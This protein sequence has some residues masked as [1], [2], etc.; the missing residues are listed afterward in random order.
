MDMN[1][2]ALRN[3]I[4]GIGENNGSLREDGFIITVASEIMAIVCLAED[5]MDLRSRLSKIVLGCSGDGKNITLGDLEAVGSVVALLRDAMKPNLVQTLEGVPTLVHGG[6]FANI[7]H[8]CSS[9]VATK[10]ALKLV[11]YVVTEAGFGADLGAE[12]FFDIKCREAGL[13]PDAVVLVATCRALKHNGGVTRKD[14]VTENIEA[15]RIGASNLIRHVENIGKYGLPVV[16]ALNKFDF[17]T[18][19]EIEV[20]RDICRDLAVDFTVCEA[21]SRGGA[22]AENLVDRVLEVLE[23]K[24]GSFRFLYDLELPLEMKI[25]T[26]AR[27]IYRARDVRFSP[28]ALKKLRQYGDGGFAKLPVCIAKTQ[29]SF[30]DDPKLLGAPKNFTLT[31]SDVSIS[32]GA[33]FVVCLAGDIM[34][35]PGLPSKPNALSIDVDRNGDIVGLF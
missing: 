10:T 7:A 11:D 20:V 9:V 22:G 4:V 29:Y 33:G 1:D 25:E 24:N 32:A 35:M 14:L 6:P 28:G 26:I 8:G 13:T 31:L 27:E 12:K 5:M 16:V 30:S 15:I 17:D 18:A 3:V 19:R 23:K 2:R 21:W 34:T